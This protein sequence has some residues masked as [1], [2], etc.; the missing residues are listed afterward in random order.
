MKIRSINT[1]IKLLKHGIPIA[2]KEFFYHV[3]IF[4]LIELLKILI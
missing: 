3:I 2:L 4:S 1:A